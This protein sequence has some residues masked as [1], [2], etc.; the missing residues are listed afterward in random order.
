[1][2]SSPA[3][4]E[5]LVRWLEQ[6]PDPELAAE[7]NYMET[8]HLAGLAERLVAVERALQSRGLYPAELAAALTRID[9]PLA[10]KTII[11]LLAGAAAAKNEDLESMAAARAV[12][13]ELFKRGTALRGPGRREAL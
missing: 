2:R 9:D 6:V 11:E 13:N 8:P 4:A 12:L 3:V 7:L 5:A 10:D 1:G